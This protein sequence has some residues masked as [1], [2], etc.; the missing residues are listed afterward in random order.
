MAR[1]TAQAGAHDGGVALAAVPLFGVVVA[2]H[3][4]A[5]PITPVTAQ[6]IHQS[7]PPGGTGFA[8]S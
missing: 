6:T 1:Q 3:R 4:L 2:H 7:P 5:E 8:C